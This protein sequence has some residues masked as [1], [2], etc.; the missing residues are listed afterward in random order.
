MAHFGIFEKY[1]SDKEWPV[2][3]TNLIVEGESD[4][5]YF[6]FASKLY[7][8]D[9]GKSLVG[10]DLAIFPPGSGDDGGTYGVQEV[11]NVAWTLTSH[12]L[13]KDSRRIYR[14]AALLDGD[15]KGKYTANSIVGSHRKIKM[16]RD[17]FVLH[18]IFPRKATDCRAVQKQVE[19]ANSQWKNL[20]TI[21]EDLFSEELIE[22]FSN[23]HPQYVKNVTWGDGT[24]APYHIQFQPDG[25]T[26]F[27]RFVFANA[28]LESIAPLIEVLRSL[29]FWMGL[30]PD[31]V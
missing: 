27:R 11:F 28:D 2:L 17:I 26:A 16:W 5:L 31:G 22:L 1:A 18:R 29:R 21:I 7:A 6:E 23:E 9:F 12:D 20:F 13:D 4:Q 10:K 8:A 3:A 25:K 15:P 24:V 19:N 14:I 30:S